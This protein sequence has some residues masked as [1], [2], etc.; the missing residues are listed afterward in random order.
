[1]SNGYAVVDVETTGLHPGQHHRVIELAI[2]RLDEDGTVADEW[3]SLINPQRDLGAQHIHGITA[4]EIRRAPTF[5][6]LAGDI[7]TQLAGRVVVAH[8]LSFDIRFLQAEFIRA[9]TKTALSAAAGLC[10]M[11]LAADYLPTVGRS[12]AACCRAAAIAHE[13][14]HSAL[15]DAHAAASLM[16]FYIRTAGQPLPWQK[17]LRTSAQQQWPALASRNTTPV[18]RRDAFEPEPHFLSRLVDRLPSVPR[19]PRAD[20]YLAVLDAA[21][22]DRHLSESEQDELL[23]TASD[24]GLTV[25]DVIGFHHEYLAELARLAWEDGVVTPCEHDD[26]RLTAE[27]LGLT[28]ADVEGMLATARVQ[29]ELLDAPSPAAE[30]SRFTLAP[31]DLVA[32]TGDMTLSR[33]EWRSK[34]IDAGL[35]VPA[36]GITKK[37]RLVVAADPDSLSGKARKARNYGIPIIKESAFAKML[38]KLS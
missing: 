3:C 25:E 34:A 5:S 20:D 21:L 27:L 29:D 30:W 17:V 23:D 10:T 31:G 24:L 1:M 11:H 12:L 7:A 15:H 38:D 9:G 4:A 8:N 2:V 32:F 26:L 33:E 28:A 19:D 14:A 16:K 6:D 35:T 22:I 18:R 37:T 36:S 13:K